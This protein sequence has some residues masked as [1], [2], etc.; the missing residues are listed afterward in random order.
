MDTL[1]QRVTKLLNLEDVTM[2]ERLAHWLELTKLEVLTYCNL[3][4]L[5]KTL[6]VVV[7]DIVAN[8]FEEAFDPTLTQ[9]KQGENSYTYNVQKVRSRLEDYSHILNNYTRM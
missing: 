9:L 5:P 8:L 3:D 7:I 6:E 2:T 4:E 1:L